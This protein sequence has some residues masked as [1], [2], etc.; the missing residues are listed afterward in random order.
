MKGFG[1]LLKEGFKNI[2]H[3]RMMS[4]ASIGVLISCMLLTGFAV[5]ICM[6]VQAVV[7]EAGQS[8]MINVYLKDGLSDEQ[9]KQ[10]ESKISQISN[11][12]TCAF[13]PKEEAILE[14]EEELGAA[15]SQ[16]QGD[17]N[18]L[19]DAFHVS[20]KDLSVYDETT[21]EIQGI[22]GVDKLSNRKEVADKLTSLS[23]LVATMGLWIVVILGIIS[24][25]IIS[26]TIRMSMYSR[27]FE[28]SIMKSV[29]ATNT[30]VRIPFLVEGMFMGAL[31]AVFASAAIWFLYDP[32]MNTAKSIIPF[33]SIPYSAFMIPVTLAFL[34][35]GILTGA[36][37][38]VISIRKYLK[39]EG[40]EVAGW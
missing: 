37:G 3:N 20:M 13:Y 30:F 16:M 10:I 24:L 5:L 2:W 8:N 21:Q 36:I 11:V 34:I 19:P 22:D 39:L 27:R 18:P 12:E 26:N 38:G 40:N 7:D 29:G 6:N 17:Q 14:F 9:E 15:F 4:A 35:C 23:N 28:I 25:F 1:Y 33:T 31:S 32:I